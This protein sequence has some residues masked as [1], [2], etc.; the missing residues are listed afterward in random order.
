MK[1]PVVSSSLN[2]CQSS[3]LGVNLLPAKKQDLFMCIGYNL[4]KDITLV[5]VELG[6]G[7]GYKLVLG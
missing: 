3:G 1:K 7:A 4:P 6:L 2:N 5:V